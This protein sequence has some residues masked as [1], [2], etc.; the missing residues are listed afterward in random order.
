MENDQTPSPLARYLAALVVAEL[1][2][3]HRYEQQIAALR[4]EAQRLATSTRPTIRAKALDALKAVVSKVERSQTNSTNRRGKAG[5]APKQNWTRRCGMDPVDA[6]MIPILL[7][8]LGHPERPADFD[9]MLERHAIE[10]DASLEKTPLRTRL[11]SL[12]DGPP[13][14]IKSAFNE[15][16]ANLPQDKDG[17]Q[18]E[19]KAILAR[20]DE[21]PNGKL[22]G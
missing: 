20:W 2:D 4:S 7:E 14:E 6:L 9:K 13:G 8:R 19:L 11:K 1:R 10:R 17:L 12:R 3:E 22:V 21:P 16:K 18:A 15:R 5:R